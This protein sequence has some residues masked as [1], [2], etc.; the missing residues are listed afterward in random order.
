MK[1]KN[2]AILLLLP[3][4]IALLGVIAVNITFK[5]FQND[6]SHIEW[7]YGDTVPYQIKEN[8][9]YPLRATGVNASNLPLAEGNQLVWSVKNSDGH[10]EP[11]AKIVEEK[12]EYYL[13]PI[14]E[15]D[16]IITCSNQKG[17]VTR[18]TNGIIYLNS[19][20]YLENEIQSS[21][22]NVDPT[23]YY[24]EYDLKDGKKVQAQVKFKVVAIPNTMEIDV[25]TTKENITFDK[26]TGI[27]T[28]TGHG[29]AKLT[30]SGGSEEDNT[31][32]SRTYSYEIVDEGVNVY[33]YDDLLHCTNRSQTGGEIVVLRKS[34]ESYKNAYEMSGDRVL[35][36]SN[37]APIKKAN[38]VEC[39]GVYDP[40]LEKC[41][42]ADDE[43]YSFPTTYNRSYIDQW[44]TFAKA[45][46]KY[47]EI[48]DTVNVGIHVQKDFYGNGYTI[49][50]HNLTFP[51]DG[52]SGTDEKTGQDVWIPELSDTDKFRGPLPFYTL[53]DPNSDPLI[54]AYGQD[55]IGMYVDGNN[56]TVN[57][58]NIKNCDVGNSFSN[59]ELVGTVLEIHGNNVTVSN[60]VLQYGRNIIR[61]FS[62]KDTVIENCLIENALN[63][64]LT[65]GSNDCAKV[66]GSKTFTFPDPNQSG[67]SVRM[68]L[69]DYLT[70][71]NGE[72]ESKN[73]NDALNDFVNGT[74]KDPQQMLS[75]L[76]ALQEALS[77]SADKTPDGSMVIKDTLFYRSGIASIALESAFNGPFLYTPSPSFIS[78]TFSSVTLEGTPLVPLTPV[79]VSG[80]SRPV[81]LK[82][83]GETKFYDYKTQEDLELKGLIDENISKY[84]QWAVDNIPALKDKKI[85]IT[86][87]DI[88]PL[89]PMLYR[90]AAKEGHTYSKEGKT[91][92]NIPI[93][94]YGG[95]LN[96]S[97]VSFDGLENANA[98]SDILSLNWVEEYVGMMGGGT[99][100]AAKGTMQKTVTA[101]TGFDPFRFVCYKGDGYLFGEQPTVEELRSNN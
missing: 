90:D 29:P 62:S 83:T 51:T 43:I 76:K 28:V 39:F 20:I 3:Y 53:G 21:Q 35:L 30:I 40:Q 66:D 27:M 87:D 47:R 56:I 12:G 36:D 65:V 23:V 57:D 54:T 58:I 88:F 41:I 13:V 25:Q 44:N 68:S 92:L 63:F 15:G 81:E 82:I 94:F 80:V 98:M 101:V 89:K 48:K 75:I 9:R 42:F 24:G 4:V 55:N 69:D 32:T 60:S 50:L 100:E 85:E 64:L 74:Y 46:N 52:Y 93:A 33:T 31:K 67:K 11:H 73:G 71:L 99:L 38:N 22:N 17:N 95:G 18:R 70:V 79:K 7:D 10:E 78:E 2:I 45:N 1:K 97:T 86:I 72:K 14:T 6:I 59:L 96:L 37:G 91:Y 49:N 34:F 26:K 16:I 19:L 61:A 5:A 77:A 8:A 84:V